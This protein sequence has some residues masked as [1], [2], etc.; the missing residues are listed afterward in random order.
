MTKTKP[1]P[2]TFFLVMVI[3]ILLTAV[4]FG[5]KANGDATRSATRALCAI[6]AGYAKQASDTADFLK[7]HPNGAPSLGLS[8]ADLLRSIAVARRNVSA[9][10]DVSCSQ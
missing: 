10:S 7:G 3:V 2:L 4:A 8:R 5:I 1:S 9:L 6:R